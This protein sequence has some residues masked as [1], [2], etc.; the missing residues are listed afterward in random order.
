VNTIINGKVYCGG[1]VIVR[2]TDDYIIYC[3]DPSQDKWTTLPP[4]PVKWFGLGQVNGKLVAVGGVKKGKAPS[5]EIY[6]FSDG[7]S[8]KWKPKLPPMPTARYGPGVLSL[9]SA[10]I[11]A[12]GFMITSS[13]YTAA[14]EIFKPDIS[15]WYMTSPLPI[16]CCNVSLAAV[17]VGKICCVLG[18]YQHPSHLNQALYASIDDL[19]GNAIRANQTAHGGSS[20]TQ[21]AWN[22]LPNT[23]TYAPSAA[24]LAGKLLAVGGKD[25][26]EGGVA[27][28]DVYM[29]SPS[30]NSWIYISDLP[31]PRF[32]TT[33][34]ILSSIEILVIGGWAA[35]RVNTVYKGMLTLL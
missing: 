25:T 1:R 7:R 27:K 9:Q 33:V 14:V 26:A 30:T 15:Q 8:Q 20:D 16:V 35:D 4:L 32:G 2:D 13:S 12:G 19:L 10:L 34:A 28:R 5:N 11:V 23:P 29:F 31:A 3:Y 21:S 18:G 6:T 17:Q 22:T 24:V